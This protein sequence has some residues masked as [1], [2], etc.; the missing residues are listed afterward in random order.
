MDAGNIWH[1][2]CA[3]HFFMMNCLFTFPLCVCVCVC[4]SR[5]YATVI[6]LYHSR[7]Q[8][9]PSFPAHKIHHH[10]NSTE[11]C[12]MLRDNKI[13]HVVL[14][15]PFCPCLLSVCWFWFIVLFFIT[16]SRCSHSQLTNRK[17]K[18]LLHLNKSNR[19]H[20]GDVLFFS[21]GSLDVTALTFRCR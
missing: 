20:K 13:M 18:S 12:M 2:R 21:I 17:E 10:Q 4:W 5:H 14:F 3:Q 9:R 1:V 8:T 7:R 11:M 15:L 19:T 16:G 6:A